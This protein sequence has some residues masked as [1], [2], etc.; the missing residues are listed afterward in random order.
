[1]TFKPANG[2]ISRTETFY[3][4]VRNLPVGEVITYDRIG[5]LLGIR[6]RPALHG[7]AR[8]VVRKMK[9]G[10]STTLKA[11]TNVGYEVVAY[12][13]HAASRAL[14]RRLNRKEASGPED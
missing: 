10:H 11:L 2:S 4:H 3:E 9:R 8:T 5:Q 12:D 6:D 1:V 14:Y 13:R 7:V